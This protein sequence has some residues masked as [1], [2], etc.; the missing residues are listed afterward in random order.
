MTVE[1]ARTHTGEEPAEQFL[2]GLVGARSKKKRRYAADAALLFEEWAKLG[3]L[4]IPMQQ[5]HLE[6]DLWEVKT[7]ALRFP[8][9]EFRDV[10]HGQTARLTHGFEK[11][12]GKTV[13]GKIPRKH[14][15][16]GLW[17]IE[18]DRKC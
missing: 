9:Y 10:E 3:R 17:M 16:K 15:N 5:R 14:L 4:E 1:A 18:E 13:E 6:G 12:I 2:A 7:Y 8:Y 11:D